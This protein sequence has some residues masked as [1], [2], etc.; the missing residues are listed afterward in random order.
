MSLAWAQFASW[1]QLQLPIQTY[2]SFAVCLIDLMIKIAFWVA[3][4]T[5]AILLGLTAYIGANHWNKL[6][7][8]KP[9]VSVTAF[10]LTSG[11]QVFFPVAFYLLFTPWFCDP[12]SL[13][14]FVIQSHTDCFGSDNLISIIFGTLSVICLLG[15]SV[16]SAF[17]KS[18]VEPVNNDF[19]VFLFF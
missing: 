3:V 16:F 12:K 1:I 18:S 10:C 8:I 5:V 15:L 2:T 6:P 7:A 4:A 19:T 17:L 14:L 11:F 13:K 9:V